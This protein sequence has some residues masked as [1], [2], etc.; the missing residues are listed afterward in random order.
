MKYHRSLLNYGQ[1]CDTC[2]LT[3]K[4]KWTDIF[5]EWNIIDREWNYAKLTSVTYKTV[6]RSIQWIH[7]G[8][9]SIKSLMRTSN[10]NMRVKDI[11]RSS[12]FLSYRG[13]QDCY[14]FCINAAPSIFKTLGFPFSFL[15]FNLFSFFFLLWQIISS[16]LEGK[17][18]NF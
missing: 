7:E 2:I 11:P 16:L 8:I 9:W 15:V 3:V 4:F 1:K 18:C 17:S 13:K 12:V 10:G 6:E 14:L 5:R